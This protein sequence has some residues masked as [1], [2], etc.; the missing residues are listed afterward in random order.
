VYIQL[1]GDGVFHTGPRDLH[2]PVGQP[3]H[4]EGRIVD[5]RVVKRRTAQANKVSRDIGERGLRIAGRQKS[6]L[7]IAG[8]QF[9]RSVGVSGQQQHGPVVGDGGSERLRQEWGYRR[10]IDVGGSRRVG[11]RHGIFD[12]A[13][14]GVD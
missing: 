10:P 12:V 7:F 13:V 14:N 8:V 9:Q 4:T 1:V 2:N 3:V 5:V 6:N 11:Y